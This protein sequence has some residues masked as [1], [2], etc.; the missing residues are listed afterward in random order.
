MSPASVAPSFPARHRPAIALLAAL[1]GLA[2]LAAPASALK[3]A[4]WN[5]IGFTGADSA[6]RNP[7]LRTVVAAL[8]P[9]VVQLQELMSSA[10]RDYFL[11]NVLNA[12]Q[13]GQWSATSYFST[14]ESAVFYK[15]A[16]VTLTFSGS[17][18]PT[19]GPRD[20]LGVRL[21]RRATRRSWRRSGST[22]C[23]SRPAPRR[24]TRTR[25][26][27]SARTSATT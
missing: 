12:V 2:F 11:T 10:A 9:D 1:A 5:V 25:G 21:R 22:R 7:N 4:T 19:A 20:V 6:S 26:S 23:T 24:P 18:I 8:D 16:K 13:P 17:A 14:C 27:S 3:V 15:P